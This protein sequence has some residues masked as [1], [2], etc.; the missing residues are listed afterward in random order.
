[1]LASLRA[2]L[3]AANSLA[4]SSSS[5]GSKRAT[6]CRAATTSSSPSIRVAARVAVPSSSRRAV[7]LARR[8]GSVAV[9]AGSETDTAAGESL[10]LRE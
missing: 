7:A 10:V 4:A 6:T 5:S 9:R 1:M 8:S 2:P 3:S